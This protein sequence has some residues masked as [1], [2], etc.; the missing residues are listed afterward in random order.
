LDAHL[1]LWNDSD[2]EPTTFAAY[3]Q[4]TGHT[5]LRHEVFFK[6]K[7]NASE[8]AD[9]KA[10]TDALNPV[11]SDTSD[12]KAVQTW[13]N[14]RTQPLEAALKRLTSYR[15]DTHER[16]VYGG[17]K[18]DAAHVRFHSPGVGALL[19]AVNIVAIGEYK[20]RR[21]EP[22]FT[23]EEI[24]HAASLL[25]DLI[26]AQNRQSPFARGYL[27]DGCFIIF[28]EV[29]RVNE[30]DVI[31]LTECLP[32]QGL[33]G[34][35]LASFYYSSLEQLGYD[36]PAIMVKQVEIKLDRV[37]GRGAQ[38]IVYQ[39]MLHGA[40][41]AVKRFPDP[42]TCQQEF[43]NWVR[44]CTR[45]QTSGSDD[46][47]TETSSFHSFCI[48]RLYAQSDDKQAL[49][50][51]PIGKP[52]AASQDQRKAVGFSESRGLEPDA[53]LL[54]IDHIA[55]LLDALVWLKEKKLVHRDLKLSN[56][57]CSPEN[58]VCD[59]LS[60]MQIV[61]CLTMLVRVVRQ[62]ML[63]DYDTLV[64]E[65]TKHR[66]SGYLAFA[67]KDVVQ[68]HQQNEEYET[69]CKHDWFSVCCI[70][71][72]R[73]SPDWDVFAESMAQTLESEK[74]KVQIEHW[75]KVQQS[76][77]WREI[78]RHAES[79]DRA[80]LMQVLKRKFLHSTPSGSITRPVSVTTVKPDDA[81]FQS[82]HRIEAVR[83]T[84]VVPWTASPV[85]SERP[86][87]KYHLTRAQAR[88]G[89]NF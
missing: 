23:D 13:F 69:R 67:P 30:R 78:F 68:A 6:S 88:A 33:G 55:A 43:D 58:E 20:R 65:G 27:T 9:V 16:P 25:R 7:G 52:F 24:G 46:E 83:E 54:S 35:Y 80:G 39:G 11:L 60:R 82:I 75:T 84:S 3:L 49:L 45:K 10:F 87:T 74:P 44:L 59:V 85:K 66:F 62:L 34:K 12:E 36:L 40:H 4:K 73:L 31:S 14:E 56:L 86:C 15:I 42:V 77:E 5:T 37:L 18:P 28:L 71:F 50:Y 48:P 72:R 19:D 8:P 81:K 57:L 63:I 26:Q 64:E 79:M 38:S 51:W 21:P 2:F 89:L 41:F 22:R 47:K 32:L 53:R 17:R 76:E 70:L 1:Q 61:Q 29:K